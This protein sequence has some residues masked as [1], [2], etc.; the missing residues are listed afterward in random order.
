MVSLDLKEEKDEP[1]TSFITPSSYF[2]THKLLNLRRRRI[3]IIC[4]S[5]EVLQIDR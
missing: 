4:G 3:L 5:M 1:K 2:G